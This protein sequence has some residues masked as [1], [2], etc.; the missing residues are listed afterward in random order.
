MSKKIYLSGGLILVEEATKNTET[1]NINTTD[2]TKSGNQLSLVDNITKQSYVLGLY[3][4][5]TD[6]DDNTFASL[7]AAS[8]YIQGLFRSI[9]VSQFAD[10]TE[11]KQVDG[12]LRTSSMP[13]TYDIAEG[14]IAGHTSL[15]KF[16]SNPDV[17][18][19]QET[20]WQQGGLYDWA[21]VDAAAGIVKVSSSS[22][23]D[24]VAGTGAWT[25]TIYGLNSTTGLEQNESII[26][27]GQTAVNSTLEY[28]RVNRVIVNTAG[29][30]LS[31]AGVIYVGT[32]AVSTGVPAVIWSTVV[33]G[34]NQTLQAI[35]TVPTGKTLYITS[36]IGSTNS[37][38]GN[39][40]KIYVR[41]EG[42]LFQIKSQFFL[43][44]TNVTHTFEFPLIVT[45]MTD[46]DIRA[47]GKAT[48]AGIGFSFEGWTE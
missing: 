21:A 2:F 8:T 40:I 4:E 37:N 22:T 27:T 45:S 9:T 46:I 29:T 7:A 19:S 30:G 10:G 26:L 16:G 6:T 36:F 33:I 13:Y 3:T 15:Y 32:G 38:K 42:E 12:K 47:V 35:W 28:S 23:D 25:C 41:P 34:E 24:D 18:T 11:Q 39:E 31:N 17:S 5:L 20:L 14:N 1:F 48:G 44:S 43:F